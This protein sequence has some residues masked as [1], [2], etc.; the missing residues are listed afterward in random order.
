[1]Q[2]FSKRCFRARWKIFSCI[3]GDI[4]NI[5]NTF[6]DIYKLYELWKIVEQVKNARN[7]NLSGVSF[8][9]YESLWNMGPEPTIKRQSIF[10]EIS[11]AQKHVHCLGTWTSMLTRPLQHLQVTMYCSIRTCLSIPRSLILACQSKYVKVNT[12]WCN[13]AYP[14]IT[15][16]NM[17]MRLLQHL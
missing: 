3:R 15:W 14:K 1:M 12:K 6:L 4:V 17:L 8:F 16:T 9:F 7:S 10:K 2:R 11:T 13:I 5:F